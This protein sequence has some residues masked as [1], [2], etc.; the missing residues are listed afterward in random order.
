MIRRPPRSTLFPYTTL[1][2]S[3]AHRTAEIP[4]LVAGQGAVWQLHGRLFYGPLA[5]E[6]RNRTFATRLPAI[7]TT[8]K[9]AAPT[10]TRSP[11]FRSRPNVPNTSPPTV[12]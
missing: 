1:F 3:R 6:V 10:V 7:S 8:S 5:P 9:L 4:F 2:R 11:G 12:L